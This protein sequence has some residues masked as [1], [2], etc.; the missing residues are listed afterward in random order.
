MTLEELKVKLWESNLPYDDEKIQK[1]ETLAKLTLL[2]NEKFN[3]TAIKDFDTFIEKM[4]FDSALGL[5]GREDL[6]NKTILDFGSGAG[7]PGL[8]LAILFPDMKITLLDSTKKKTDHLLRMIEFLGL[9]NADV[10]CAR[11]EEYVKEHRESFDYVIARAVSALNI[12]VELCSPFVKVGG[13][14]VSMKGKQGFLEYESSKSAVEK[15]GL[16]LE[17]ICDEELPSE[18]EERM[19]LFLDKIKSTPKKY[20]RPYKEIM[21]KPL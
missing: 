14:F 5:R 20:P 17:N 1:L 3:L 19:N 18:H 9:N 4:I 8:V 6:D 16:R 12:L 13:V 10:V 21:A 7:F 11:G 2:E 15:V